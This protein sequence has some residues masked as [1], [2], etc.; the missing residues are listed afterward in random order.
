MSKKTKLEILV[1]SFTSQSRK[2]KLATVVAAFSAPLMLVSSTAF[3]RSSFTDHLWQ[4]A[5]AAATNMIDFNKGYSRIYDDGDLNL[6]TDSVMYLR[7]PEGV[8]I[9]N[10]LQ[11]N[12]NVNVDGSLTVAG[13]VNGNVTGDLTGNVS[14]ATVDTTGDV[15]VGGDANVTGDV[16]AT[17]IHATGDVTV[18]GT[19]TADFT[20]DNTL[21]GVTGNFDVAGDL[22]A[23]GGVSQMFVDTTNHN[24]DQACV[25]LGQTSAVWEFNNS[26]ES[27]GIALNDD[28]VDVW[29]PGDSGL[30]RLFDED[31][32]CTSCTL[33][34]PGSSADVE[35]DFAIS[36]SGGVLAKGVSHFYDDVTVDGAL[37]GNVTGDVTGALFGNADTATALAADPADCGADTYATTIATNGD[38]TCA[39]ITDAALSANVALLDA[40]QIFTGTNTFTG[41]VN[42]GDFGGATADLT[43]HGDVVP[44]TDT[45]HSLGTALA[46]WAELN[47]VDASITGTLTADLTGNADTATDFTGSLVGDVTGT[48]GATVV[49]SVSCATC[50]GDGALSANVALYDAAAPT[51]T[52]DLTAPNFIGDLTG[53]VIGTDVSVSGIL[54][55]GKQAVVVADNG[56]GTAATATITPSSSYI[57]I[58]CQDADGCDVTMGEGGETEGNLAILVSVGDGNTIN[59]AD[60]SGV[61]E[62]AGT[63]NAG[64]HDSLTLAYDGT[65]WVEVSRSNN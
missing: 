33:G 52:N 11:A 3:A 59:F 31:N 63:F 6:A 28:V 21:D 12:H 29:S 2:I 25:D 49:S 20:V 16:T 54:T 41:G 19:L 7:A 26:G 13:T 65:T 9:A 24:C 15:T 27:S 55:L 14:G 1:S 53:N 56:L 61:S 18:D 5:N 50:V 8:I 30:L 17:N 23:G 32:F 48:Q 35:A 43:V 60:T 42:I 64:L 44:D 22:T 4:F 40:T 37:L 58:N 39:S 38:L 51:F 57:E 47:V 45:F 10:N 46:S 34:L 62:L 36:G